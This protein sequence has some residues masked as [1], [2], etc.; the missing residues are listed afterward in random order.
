MATPVRLFATANG[1]A[2]LATLNDAAAL[3]LAR[4]DGL[5]QIQ[6]TARS[7]TGEAAL[8]ADI[9]RVRARGYGLAEEEAEL[10]VFAIAVA[11][12]GPAGARGTLSIGGP[13][14]RLAH[15]I[16]ELAAE[17]QATAAIL[18]GIWPIE[19]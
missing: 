5:G 19:P 1:K 12:P 3:A 14:P 10:G 13:S 7:H 8:L 18:A 11:I 17:L 15:R 16:P 2:F 9:Q 4:K 6:P